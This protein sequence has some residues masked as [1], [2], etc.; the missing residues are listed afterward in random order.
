M[1]NP[2]IYIIRRLPAFPSAKAHRVVNGL[3]P[4]SF[5]P[6]TPSL[7]LN[8]PPHR[9]SRFLCEVIFF[10]PFFSFMGLTRVPIFSVFYVVELSPFL[11]S[12]SRSQPPLPSSTLFLYPSLRSSIFS[13]IS[14][15]FVFITQMNNRMNWVLT[16][17]IRHIN[18]KLGRLMNFLFV[19][20]TRNWLGK[21]LQAFVFW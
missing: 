17:F 8:P 3:P 13:L 20:T 7:Q 10:L 4:I 5:E 2:T 9:H 11:L 21:C 6:P 1:P 16:I 14:K 19:E 18:W 12:L 15:I